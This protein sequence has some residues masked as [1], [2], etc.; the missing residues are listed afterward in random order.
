MV[1]GAAGRSVYCIN[2]RVVGVAEQ[3]MRG[4]HWSL[5]GGGERRRGGPRGWAEEEK[6]W[7]KQGTFLVQE[8][9]NF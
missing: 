3:R 1:V 4:Q 7:I 2:M 6:S 8:R 5:S 9:G